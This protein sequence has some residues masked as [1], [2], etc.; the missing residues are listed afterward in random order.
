[1]GWDIQINPTSEARGISWNLVETLEPFLQDFE[2]RYCYLE[3]ED[4][5]EL[6]PKL[7]A[8]KPRGDSEAQAIREIIVLLERGETVELMLGH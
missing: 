1:V 6:M 5:E 2:L 7:R 3:P 8:L 4:A